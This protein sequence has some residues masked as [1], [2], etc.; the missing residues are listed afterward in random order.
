MPPAVYTPSG[1]VG[2][3]SGVD[4]RLQ[5]AISHGDGQLCY[6]LTICDRWSRFLLMCHALPSPSATATKEMFRRAFREY[7]CPTRIRIGDNGEPLP[8]PRWAACRGSRLIRSAGH[9]S[10]RL[11][12][13]GLAPVERRVTSGCIARSKRTSRRPPATTGADQHLRFAAFRRRYNRLRPHEAL[14]QQPPA[15][16]HTPSPRRWQRSWNASRLPR[17]L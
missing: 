6:P 16:P 1:V 11:D 12:R 4:R 9:L 17:P 8:P 5:G 10:R 2:A 14:G 15:A 3:E 13:A 7:G